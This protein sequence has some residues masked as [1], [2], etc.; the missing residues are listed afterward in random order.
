MIPNLRHS[1]NSRGSSAN[2]NRDM[3]TTTLWLLKKKAPDLYGALEILLNGDAEY[4]LAEPPDAHNPIGQ[5]NV[6]GLNGGAC[7]IM[8][9]S[10]ECGGSISTP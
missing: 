1:R 4:S 8:H 10:N 7:D 9:C 6:I 5:A 2:S 3:A